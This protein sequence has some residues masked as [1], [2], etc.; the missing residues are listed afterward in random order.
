MWPDVYSL[1]LHLTCCCHFIEDA[2]EFTEQA[3]E[4]NLR[5]HFKIKH[6]QLPKTCSMMTFLV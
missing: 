5:T 1:L 6:A 2:P 3:S 4:Y